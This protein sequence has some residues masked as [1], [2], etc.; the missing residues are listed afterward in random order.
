MVRESPVIQVPN[1]NQTIINT[2]EDNVALPVNLQEQTIKNAAA[3]PSTIPAVINT[4]I[5]QQTQ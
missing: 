1:S 2:T 4:P 5:E 3:Q